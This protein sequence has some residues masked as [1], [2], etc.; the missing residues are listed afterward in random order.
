MSVKKTY[1]NDMAMSAIL[2]IA[3]IIE[4]SAARAKVA[5]HLPV[6]DSW[7]EAARRR[8]KQMSPLFV[9]TIELHGST[10][11][12]MYDH[13]PGYAYFYTEGIETINAPS[14]C[15]L[16][17][18]MWLG[19]EALK[20]AQTALRDDEEEYDG[21]FSPS[22]IILK[23]QF[24][25]VVQEYRTNYLGNG[26]YTTGWIIDLP[27]EN[28]WAQLESHASELDSEAAIEIGWDNF[29]TGKGLRQQADSL[30]RRV[31]IAR[32]AQRVVQ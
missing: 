17:H 8:V 26:Q 20:A 5:L 25:D 14:Y 15:R 16:S 11:R 19:E 13:A 18:A 6:E 9:R 27:L 2:R 31:S 22:S 23:D 24:G 32:A 30:R 28:E 10:C 21:R 3:V 4:K 1:A 29:E 12:D 7:E